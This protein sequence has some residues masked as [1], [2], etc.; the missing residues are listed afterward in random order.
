M[1]AHAGAAVQCATS[2]STLRGP[3][4][5]TACV[6]F[7]VCAGSSYAGS[8]WTKDNLSY[9]SRWQWRTS[10][11][12]HEDCACLCGRT[13]ATYACDSDPAFYSSDSYF[14]LYW[15]LFR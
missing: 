1:A 14:L 9:L 15:H 3:F 2:S 6:M 4:R 5:V 12:Q 8:S 10:P 11:S 13:Q 7:H